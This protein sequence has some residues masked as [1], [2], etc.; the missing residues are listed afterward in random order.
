MNEYRARRLKYHIYAIISKMRK[1]L[2]S[3]KKNISIH[4]I[5]TYMVNLR[6]TT[7]IYCSKLKGAPGWPIG[8]ISD[9]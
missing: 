1:A 6:L 5:S 2:Y 3:I 4:N 7:V 9:W 8:S